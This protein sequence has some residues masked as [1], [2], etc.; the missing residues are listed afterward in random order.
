MAWLVEGGGRE[1]P[2]MILE[3]E[4]ERRDGE[5]WTNHLG[6][7]CLRRIS[8]KDA[9]PKDMLQPLYGPWAN[10]L[11]VPGL[12]VNTYDLMVQAYDG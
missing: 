4:K 9:W 12:R 6:L 2:M 7:E 10:L 3:R 5:I 11:L 1:N 8:L